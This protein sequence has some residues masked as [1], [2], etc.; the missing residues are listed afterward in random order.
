[1]N[2]RIVVTMDGCRIGKRMARHIEELRGRCN[3]SA[4]TACEVFDITECRPIPKGAKVSIEDFDGCGGDA[5]MFIVEY[6][7]RIYMATPDELS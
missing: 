7:G 5:G 3:H 1:M 6:R 2:K 4:Y